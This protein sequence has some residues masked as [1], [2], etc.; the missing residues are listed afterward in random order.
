MMLSRRMLIC[1]LLGFSS[2]MPLYVIQQLLP[3]WLRTEGVRLSDIAL[4]QLV[5]LPYVWKFIWAP[6]ADR[7]VP[8]FLGRRRGWALVTQVAL[9][10]L[11]A[12]FGAFDPRGSILAIAGVAVAV[13]LFSATQDI[14]VDAYRREL[15]SDDE[16]GLGNALFVNAYRVSGLVPG[17]L[18]LILADRLPWSV[19]HGIVA[20]FM[21]VGILTTLSVSEPPLEPG[22]PRSLKDAVLGPF[23]E[24]FGRADLASAFRVLGFLFLYKL[25]DS[26]ATTLATPFYIDLGFSMTEIGSVAKLVGFSATIGGSVLGGVLMMRL[27]INRSLWIFGWVQ[28]V[29]IL[30]FAVLSEVGRSLSMLAGVVLCEYLGVGLG[31]AAFVAYMARATDRRFSATQYALFS[32]FIAVPRTVVGSSTGRIVEAIGYTPFFLLC[33]ALALPGM[34]L[35]IRVAPWREEAR[36]TVRG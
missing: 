1:I 29:S 21:G 18:A 11:I 22:A 13:S 8:P 31:T 36:P 17:A 19:V 4:F 25:G 33:T 16:L 6:L 35:L 27:G 12:S 28:L 5:Q 7:Y 32:S 24:F 30:G 3:A 9:F 34:L 14:V 10:A 26:M 2:G 15:L 20:A 23:L